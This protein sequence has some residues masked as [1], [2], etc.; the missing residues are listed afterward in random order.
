[1]NEKKHYNVHHCIFI[2]RIGDLKSES[3]IQW[4][5][6]IVTAITFSLFAQWCFLL[7][8]TPRKIHT[9]T[10]HLVMAAH[11][12]TIQTRSTWKSKYTGGETQQISFVK[13]TRISWLVQR[14]TFRYKCSTTSEGKD[15]IRKE[16]FVWK[17][18]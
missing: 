7:H 10:T 13:F 12:E 5:N 15:S 18:S 8:L 2:R 16:M 3:L 6:Y 17:L 14:V 9:C 11:F 1:M 4:T